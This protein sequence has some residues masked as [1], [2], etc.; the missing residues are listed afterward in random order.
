LCGLPLISHFNQH[1]KFK[2]VGP[3][4]E[5]PD[6]ECSPSY[7]DGI[8]VGSGDRIGLFTAKRYGSLEILRTDCLKQGFPKRVKRTGNDQVSP[9]H[10]NRIGNEQP[11]PG[12]IIVDFFCATYKYS[13]ANEE[14]DRRYPR[15][16]LAER[17]IEFFHC[18]VIDLPSSGF[19]EGNRG[20]ELIP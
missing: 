14:H 4:V 3:V 6:P 11:G 10:V 16:P 12:T 18:H 13:Q 5:I 2:A 9:L 7:I 19:Y 1:R 15:G 20:R 17:W 8:R